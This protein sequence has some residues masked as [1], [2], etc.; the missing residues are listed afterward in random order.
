MS[1]PELSIL[2]PAAGCSKRLGQPKQLVQYKSG[3]LIQ[4]A[5]HHAYSI[6]P[7]E[8]IVVTGANAKAVENAVHQTTV[9]WIHNPHWPTGMG[10][11]IAVGAAA[12][13][14]A[15]SGVMILLCDQWRLQATDLQKLAQTWQSG[16]DRIICA[17]ADGQN[18]PPVIF[19]AC[20][21]RRLQALDKDSGARTILE[22]NPGILTPVP[23]KNAGFDLDTK[24]HFDQLK[25]CEL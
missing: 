6:A 15:A 8:I 11:S 7:L 9:R 2:I 21:F 12:I 13:S 25:M 24:A 20:L 1:H 22:E 4:N 19:P 16:H 14:P 17:R 23:L 5:V 18:M 3:T 10:G